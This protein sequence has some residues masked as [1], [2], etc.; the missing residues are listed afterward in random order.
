MEFLH[1][2]LV[3]LLV[4][5]AMEV[6]QMIVHHAKMILFL[7]MVN[8]FLVALKGT[9]LVLTINAMNVFHYV[10]HALVLLQMNV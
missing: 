8:V 5:H 1:A 9:I 4:L 6:L 10:K 3:I 7:I 2:Y